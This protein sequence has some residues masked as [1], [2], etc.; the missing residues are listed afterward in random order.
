MESLP[1]A[2]LKFFTSDAAEYKL[3]ELT[4]EEL[5]KKTLFVLTVTMVHALLKL[6]VPLFFLLWKNLL[7]ERV[8]KE[9]DAKE[10]NRFVSISIMK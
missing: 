8:D 4:S 5:K 1:R 6:N 10:R 9:N 7:K 3:I 2:G